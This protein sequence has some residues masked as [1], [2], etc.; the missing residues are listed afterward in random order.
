[1]TGGGKNLET[2][3]SHLETT[4]ADAPDGR[5]RVWRTLGRSFSVLFRNF[6]SFAILMTVVCLVVEFL[7]KPITPLIVS[8]TGLGLLGLVSRHAVLTVLGA[9]SQVPVEAVIGLAAWRHM[10]GRRLTLTGSIARV[11]RSIPAVVHRPCR[12]FVSRVFM[13]A[14]LRA[15]L[16]FPLVLGIELIGHLDMTA[17]QMGVWLVILSLLHGVADTLIDTR[18]LILMPVVAVE[19]TGVVGSFR[20]CWRLTA[21]HWPRILGILLLAGILSVGLAFSAGYWT[22]VAK[23]ESDGALLKTLVPLFPVA[24]MFMRG[25][26]AVVAGICYHGVRMANGEI[27]PGKGSPGD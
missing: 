23:R 22:A 10:N 24:S 16:S 8:L 21:R 11:V 1:M 12:S 14:L 13:V 15:G 26:W 25:Y 2:D 9:F 4:R 17:R 6:G 5:I 7:L 20:R 3:P 19:G 27:A 18:L